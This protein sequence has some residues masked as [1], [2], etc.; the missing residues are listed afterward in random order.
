MVIKHYFSSHSTIILVTFALHLL[1]HPNLP[2]EYRS[3]FLLVKCQ[4]NSFL[5]GGRV[6]PSDTH[7][8]T[9]KGKSTC[10]PGGWVRGH[11]KGGGSYT[12]EMPQNIT[13]KDIP[14]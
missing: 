1:S 13:G 7:Q 2:V 8:A 12:K 10:P 4:N 6:G 5:G 14:L 3:I 11:Q 9:E